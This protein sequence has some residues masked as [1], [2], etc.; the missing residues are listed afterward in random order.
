[1]SVTDSGFKFSAT[2]DG[3]AVECKFDDH[4]LFVLVWN[5]LVELEEQVDVMLSSTVHFC[6]EEQPEA[7]QWVLDICSYLSN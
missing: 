1:L 4:E 3:E 5:R 6:N 7:P 2:I